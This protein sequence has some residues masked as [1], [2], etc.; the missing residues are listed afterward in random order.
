MVDEAKPNAFGDAL[1][2]D[3]DDEDPAVVEGSDA[4]LLD[5]RDDG[6]FEQALFLR[7]CA[8]SDFFCVGCRV[9]EIGQF[10]LFRRVVGLL[11]AQV[12]P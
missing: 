12:G 6:V 8:T 7:A 3:D 10:L 9:Q 5:S 2:L 11:F 1:G 4:L